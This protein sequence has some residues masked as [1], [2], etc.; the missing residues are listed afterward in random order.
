MDKKDEWK[1]DPRTDKI[2][3]EVSKI[4]GQT[5]NCLHG[6]QKNIRDIVNKIKDILGE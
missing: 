3:K 2:R 1:N 4:M 6:S 5:G